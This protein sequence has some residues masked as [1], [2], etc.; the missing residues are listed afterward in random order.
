VFDQHRRPVTDLQP[1]EFTVLEDGKGRPIVAFVP[2]ALTET[3]ARA[4]TQPLRSAFGVVPNQNSL[5]RSLF[6]AASRRCTADINGEVLGSSRLLFFRT[7]PWLRFPF[8][9]AHCGTR[10]GDLSDNRVVIGR[11]PGLAVDRN[12]RRRDAHIG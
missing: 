2:V 7:R 4:A 5:G 3:A 12:A 1:S 10:Q 8:A 6:A 11:E 9:D